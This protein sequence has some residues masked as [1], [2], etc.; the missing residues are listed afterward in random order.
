MCVGI[1]ITFTR[2]VVTTIGASSFWLRRADHEPCRRPIGAFYWG[3]TPIGRASGDWQLRKMLIIHIIPVDTADTCWPSFMFPPSDPFS[4][5][6]LMRHINMVATN[7][8]SNCWIQCMVNIKTG[9][10]ILIIETNVLIGRRWEVVGCCTFHLFLVNLA[11][12][13][14]HPWRHIEQKESYF[15]N[16]RKW[17]YYI[18]NT[19]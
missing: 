3:F 11:E 16:K 19:K 13:F 14:K 15:F 4:P 7:Y 18:P 5:S 2:K 6:C 8:Y 1:L 10:H 17:Q 12:T 9:C